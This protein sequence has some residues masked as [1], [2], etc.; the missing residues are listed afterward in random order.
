M[1]IST[2][3]ALLITTSA[4][5]QETKPETT[6]PTSSEPE[7]AAPEMTPEAPPSDHSQWPRNLWGVYGGLGLPHVLNFGVEFLDQSKTWAV[8]LDVGG[9]SYKPKDEENDKEEISLGSFALEGRYHPFTSSFYIA[10]AVGTQGVEAKK[11]ASYSGQSVTPKVKIG[12]TFVTPKVGWFWQFNSGLNF[13]VELGAQIPISKK[14]DVEDGTTD[15][16]VI[17]D[18]E[19][20]KNKQ[21]VVDIA[22][23]LGEQVLPHALVRVGYA[24]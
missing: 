9:F 7:A 11:T 3:T 23:K 12:N 8:A 18:P 20:I 17:N 6:T 15:P 13:G 21:D 2:M 24:F 19:Y 4:F 16:V 22:E 5:A 10:G 1:L 14:V